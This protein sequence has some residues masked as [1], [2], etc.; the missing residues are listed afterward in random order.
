MHRI[1]DFAHRVTRWSAWFSGALLLAAA[2]LI[3]FEVMIRKVFSLSIGGSEEL[4]G[5]ALAAATAWGLA[6]TLYERGHIRIDSLYIHLPERGR[7]GLDILGL[8]IFLFFFGLTMWRGWEVFLTSWGRNARTM[9]SMASPLIYPQFLWGLGLTVAVGLGVLLLAGAIVA[10]V[11]GDLAH[12]RALVGS[13]AVREE[14]DEE[15]ALS[16]SMRGSEPPKEM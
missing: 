4:S 6:Y 7:A 1:L 5:F 2:F 14:L 12:M 11:R 8:V 16:K 9:S 13:K 3:C 15:L 10:Y